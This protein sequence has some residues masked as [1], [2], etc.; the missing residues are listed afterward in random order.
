MS[1]NKLSNNNRYPITRCPITKFPITRYPINKVSTNKVSN[2]KVS[3][4]K[5]SN[6]KNRM[7]CIWPV[8]RISTFG[9]ARDNGVTS[10]QIFPSGLHLSLKFAIFRVFSACFSCLFVTQQQRKHRRCVVLEMVDNG[11][12][13]CTKVRFYFRYIF[14]FCLFTGTI[15]RL[16]FT[17]SLVKNVYGPWK[18]S[19]TFYRY[20][21]C[22]VRN[23]SDGPQ[24]GWTGRYFYGEQSSAAK[25]YCL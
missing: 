11:G 22:F 14:Q 4:N 16:Q 19:G 2:N 23:L 3:N 13:M 21:S 6:N 12:Q 8:Q 10:Q 17:I 15:F 5:V 18:N 25:W 20:S 9:N 24:N 1:N 7:P